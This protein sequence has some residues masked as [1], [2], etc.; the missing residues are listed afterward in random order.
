LAFDYSFNYDVLSN[1]NSA[2]TALKNPKPTVIYIL[3]RKP[4]EGDG[5]SGKKDGLKNKFDGQTEP[6]KGSGTR[7]G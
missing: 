3:G 5:K 7:K 4:G 6:G 2:K 1:R